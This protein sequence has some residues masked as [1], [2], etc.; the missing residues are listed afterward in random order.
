MSTVS[1]TRKRFG[2]WTRIAIAISGLSFALAAIDLRTDLH[3]AQ[4]KA[5]EAYA[6]A[7]APDP[8]ATMKPTEPIYKY[9]GCPLPV[10]TPQ[11]AAAIREASLSDASTA[12]ATTALYTWLIPTALI[13]VLFGGIGWIRRGFQK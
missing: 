4:S 5:D 10:V 9:F 11:K 13:A 12:A 8:C 3:A 2:G 6:A 7:V 1:A